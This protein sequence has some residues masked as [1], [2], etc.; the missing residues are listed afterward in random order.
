[1]YQSKGRVKMTTLTGNQINKFRLMTL[2]KGIELEGK[3]L[4]VSRGRSCMA[5]V[6]KEFGWT[7]NR[8]KILVLLT[9][10]IKD[11]PDTP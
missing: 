7:G 3:G 1:M 5:I 4:K 2:Q 10:H 6:K 9:D 8:N 11:M